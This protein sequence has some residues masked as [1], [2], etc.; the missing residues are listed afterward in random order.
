MGQCANDTAHDVVEEVVEPHQVQQQLAAVRRQ[1]PPERRSQPARAGVALDDLVEG[2]AC[3]TRALD[4]VRAAGGGAGLGE[5]R[6]EPGECVGIQAVQLVQ[7]AYERPA[8]S[9]RHQPPRRTARAA[10]R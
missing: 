7:M 10:S 5:E 4:R 9:E 1:L 8:E 6:G 2:A 3:I